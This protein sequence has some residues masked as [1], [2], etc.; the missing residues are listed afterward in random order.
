MPEGTGAVWPP[1]DLTPAMPA[2]LR[3]RPGATPVWQWDVPTGRVWSGPS[4]AAQVVAELDADPARREQLLA[5]ALARRAA[6]PPAARRRGYQADLVIIDET[7]TFAPSAAMSTVVDVVRRCADTLAVLG[8]VDAVRRLRRAKGSH[9]VVLGEAS[10]CLAA[11]RPQ[12][13]EG[14][15]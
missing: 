14:A 9:V 5:D 2:P 4:R 1:E 7:R 3:R 10:E 12:R 15:S 13:S 6:L 8:F 11:P